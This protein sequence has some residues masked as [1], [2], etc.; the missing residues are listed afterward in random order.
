MVIDREYPS[1]RRATCTDINCK[2][3]T[4]FNEIISNPSWKYTTHN[5]PQLNL[6]R[7][8]SA[9]HVLSAPELSPEN[10]KHGSVTRN[11]AL[12]Y[13]CGTP[14]ILADPAYSPYQM[15]PTTFPRET[16]QT[17]ISRLH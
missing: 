7:Y 10:M 12:A 8:P 5:W 1:S 3:K 2:I 6:H 17:P 16:P 13:P 4:K 15:S 11:P 14:A 9:V